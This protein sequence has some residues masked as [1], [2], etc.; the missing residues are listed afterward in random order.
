M[1]EFS[2]DTARSRGFRRATAGLA[3]AAGVGAAASLVVGAVHRGWFDTFALTVFAF[4]VAGGAVIGA[5]LL[6]GADDD[7]DL[8][9]VLA[10]TAVGS[11]VLWVA[12]RVSGSVGAA[13]TFTMGVVAVIYAWLGARA[14]HPSTGRT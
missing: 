14:R 11:V 10:P 12:W 1:T 5:L 3:L 2:A 7:R 13:A 9:F 4:L 8:Y 6:V